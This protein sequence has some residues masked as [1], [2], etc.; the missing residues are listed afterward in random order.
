M[1]GR[2]SSHYLPYLLLVLT[3]LFWAGNG[4]AGRLAVTSN[5]EPLGLTF[6]RWL[7]ALTF[8]V[9]FSLPH[10]IAERAALV[11]HWRILAILGAL[12]VTA[13]TAFYYYALSLSTAINV[14]LVAATMPAAIVGLSWLLFRETVTSRALIGMLVAFIGVVA[15]IARGDVSVLW[16][17]GFNPGDLVALG[18][19]FTW[20]L[21]S[22]LLRYRPRELHSLTFLTGIILPGVI[23]NLGVLLIDAD[24]VSVKLNWSNVTL[25]AY[26]GLFPSVLAYVFFNFGVKAVG[27]NLSGQ[28]GYLVPLFAAFLAV[29]ILGETFESYHFIGM[30]VIFFGLYLASRSRT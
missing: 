16:E 28:F 30:V 27:A 7:A 21:Y 29:S 11:R 3:S 22:V 18:A 13:F 4:I 12:S 24:S 5:I 8:L 17:L 20:A 23:I 6:W 2:Y 15:I 19:V 25:I 14:T 1:L 9:P 10:I 26:V